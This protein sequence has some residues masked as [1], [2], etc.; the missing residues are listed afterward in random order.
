M[1]RTTAAAA[2]AAALVWVAAWA[3]SGATDEGN[4]EALGLTEGQARALMNPALAVFLLALRAVHA[5]QREGA[6]RLSAAG[7]LLT[8]AGLAVALAGN[9][10]E[11]GVTGE[12]VSVWGWAPFVLGILVAAVGL[13]VL[14]AAR[15]RSATVR[16]WTRWVPLAGGLLMLAGVPVEALNE[17]TGD[18]DA[19]P[20]LL[21]L[22]AG[23]AA[24]CLSLG[25]AALLPPAGGAAGSP[26]PA[27][28]PRG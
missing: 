3:I 27:P 1:S 19:I 21:M 11:F 10:V 17:A 9:L 12:G 7:A 25:L 20:G 2:V 6:R 15:L 22:F 16:G 14:G 26:E 8:A 5:E 23:P 28:L 4:R 18:P 13:V 24:V